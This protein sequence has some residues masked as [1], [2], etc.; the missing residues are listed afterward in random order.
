MPRLPDGTESGSYAPGNCLD[1]RDAPG[2][3]SLAGADFPVQKDRVDPSKYE[4]EGAPV[5]TGAG[6]ARI[7]NQREVS[8]GEPGPKHSWGTKGVGPSKY[9][10]EGPTFDLST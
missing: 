10:F 6:P 8:T 7:V 3:P 9:E 2:A 1:L 4:F 5:E